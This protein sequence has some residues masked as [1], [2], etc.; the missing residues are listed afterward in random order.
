M[1]VNIFTRSSSTVTLSPKTSVAVQTQLK[2]QFR[3]P[4]QPR[5][6]LRKRTRASSGMTLRVLAWRRGTRRLSGE[7]PVS[8]LI[9]AVFSASRRTKS[10]WICWLTAPRRFLSLGRSRSS[11]CW[12]K[13]T[14]TS[15]LIT[16]FCPKRS[17]TSRRS[18][19]SSSTSRRPI[20]SSSL[21]SISSRT[22]SI[23][24]PI[25]VLSLTGTTK[26][27]LIY[28]SSL[29]FYQPQWSPVVSTELLTS[30]IEIT[31]KES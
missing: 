4:N 19:L 6:R 29:K 7:R 31:C 24:C 28:S 12:E 2:P 20:I 10:A 18:Y 26:V 8:P 17:W 3:S 13:I 1:A 15:W 30:S 16:C 25:P 21:R 9:R 14:S 11:C 27:C 5:E 22:S 23:L